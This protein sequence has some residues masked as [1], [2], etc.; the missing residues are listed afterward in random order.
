M[1]KHEGMDAGFYCILFAVNKISNLKYMYFLFNQLK[2]LLMCADLIN[3]GIPC[4]ALTNVAFYAHAKV[5]GYLFRRTNTNKC[6]FC[7]KFN[8]YVN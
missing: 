3:K 7:I 1:V 6:C 2:F 4:R 5:R 8:V